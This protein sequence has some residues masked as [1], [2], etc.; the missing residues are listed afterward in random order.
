MPITSK[1]IM[2][3]SRENT[4]KGKNPI[5]KLELAI[6]KAD[7]ETIKSIFKNKELAKD[8]DLSKSTGPLTLA[9]AFGHLDIVQYLL[10][11]QDINKYTDIKSPNFLG[12]QMACNNGFIEVVKY[13]TSSP[14][15]NQHIEIETI[16]DI[17]FLTC[18]QYNQIE[19]LKHFIFDLN[20]EKNKV[21]HLHLHNIPNY[22]VEKMFKSR[23]LNTELN[24]ALNQYKDIKKKLKI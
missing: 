16:Q 20:I 12:F 9:C 3:Q 2:N 21:V 7:L 5:A 15:L 4:Y 6:Q 13:L 17:G 11:S 22:E 10:T 18:L 19:I 1:V 24:L 14:N 23:E 8:I